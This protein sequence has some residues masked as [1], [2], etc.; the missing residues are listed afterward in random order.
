MRS[1]GALIGRG[2][3]RGFLLAV[4]F[5]QLGL[6]ALAFEGGQVVH[7]ELALEVVHFV[8]DTDGEDAFGFQFEGVAVPVQRLHADLAGPGDQLVI[9]RY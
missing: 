6:D 3:G 5:F 1:D 7:E 4:F 8:L 9:A 2:P